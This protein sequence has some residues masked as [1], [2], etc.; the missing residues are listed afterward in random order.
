MPAIHFNISEVKC[1]SQV[2]KVLV[3]NTDQSANDCTPPQCVYKI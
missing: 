3:Q 2:K 1:K